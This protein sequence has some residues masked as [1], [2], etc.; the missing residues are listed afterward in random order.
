MRKS[1]TLGIL[2]LICY[3]AGWAN[4]QAPSE[5]YSSEDTSHPKTLGRKLA[6][7][8]LQDQKRIWTS[9]FHTSRRDAKWWLIF[10]GATAALIAT[11]KHTINTFENAPGQIRWANRVSSVGA[12]YTVVPIAAGFY[13]AGA[14][15]DNAK[16]RETGVLGA[17]A[18]LDTAILGAVLK[19]IAGRNRPNSVSDRQEFFDG[20]Q[21]FPSGHSLAAW[22]LA[23]VVAH[24]YAQTRWVPVVAYGLSTLVSAARFTAQQH[25][26]S[27]VVA[28]AGMGWFVGRYVW[29][30]HQ[31]QTVREHDVLKPRIAPL[32]QPSSGTYGIGLSWS[33]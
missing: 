24:E 12:G 32:L 23:S 2:A 19:P 20:G 9:P 17:E 3:S 10:G 27:D 21:S 16:A 6:L 33:K 30:S 14:F 25:Y 4:A 22:S 28:G 1:R 13:I 18:L 11:D 29:R 5:V 31:D 7:Y 15:T 26:L 8:T